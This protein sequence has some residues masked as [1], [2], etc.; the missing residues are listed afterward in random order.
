MMLS[1]MGRHDE[2]IPAIEKAISLE[3]KSAI[4]QAA[5]G[6]VYFYAR[7]FEDA[8][9]ATDKVLEINEGF[10]PAY[11]IKRSVYEAQGNG[12]AAISAYQNERI[13]SESTDEDDEGWLMIAAQV[14]AVNGNRDEALA[15]LKR[16]STAAIVKSSPS[17]FAYEMALGYA[18]ANDSAS[19]LDWLEKAKT[20]RAY[21]FN[22]AKVDPRLDSI[23]NDARFTA[24]V[25]GR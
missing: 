19:A 22:F 4:I 8:L 3:P 16:A 14:S 15:M 18:L 9:L 12:S 25:D 10:V 24:L 6:S 2:A 13:Y 20:A 5:A 7:R 23:R 11:K 21:G 1:A 17:A